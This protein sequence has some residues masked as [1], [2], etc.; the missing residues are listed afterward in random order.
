MTEKPTPPD[1]WATAVILSTLFICLLLGMA[2]IPA[3]VEYGGNLNDTKVSL[4]IMECRTDLAKGSYSA[5]S[6]DRICG[7]LPPYSPTIEV[8]NK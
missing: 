4:K 3:F 6:I 2:I 1:G 7:T 5:P 8:A